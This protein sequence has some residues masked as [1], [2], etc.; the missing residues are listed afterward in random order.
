MTKTAN[1]V[2]SGNHGIDSS[3]RRGTVEVYDRGE[4]LWLIAENVRRKGADLDELAH[5]AALTEA[6]L[7]DIRTMID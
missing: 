2:A 1:P 3:P 7:A 4:L 5:I 6:E